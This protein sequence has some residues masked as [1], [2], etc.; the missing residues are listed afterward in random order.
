MKLCSEEGDQLPVIDR[1]AI[2]RRL[3][4]IWRYLKSER[5]WKYRE[6]PPETLFEVLKLNLLYADEWEFAR[7][8]WLWLRRPKPLTESLL[9]SLICVSGAPLTICAK[10][11]TP[12]LIGLV[13]RSASHGDCGPGAT[14]D[15]AASV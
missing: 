10:G 11:W 3:M 6:L 2:M 12:T 13:H 9:R 7:A 5:Q 15:L 1:Y 8:G 4:R 14:H